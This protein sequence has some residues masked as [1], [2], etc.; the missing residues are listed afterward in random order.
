MAQPVLVWDMIQTAKYSGKDTWIHLVQRVEKIERVHHD[1]GS[2]WAPL[3]FF[4]WA[5]REHLSHLVSQRSN[6]LQHGWQAEKQYGFKRYLQD[7]LIKCRWQPW[8]QVKTQ[9]D[10]VPIHGTKGRNVA[11]SLFYTQ[12]ACWQNL[13]LMKKLVYFKHKLGVI[14]HVS[15]K[16]EI[17]M[18]LQHQGK[19]FP[20]G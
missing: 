13:C 1:I 5:E 3:C 19:S 7:W 17:T 12:A 18:K 6:I 14:E 11:P 15:L 2:V 9:W 8:R 10:L 4:V 16:Q 20:L